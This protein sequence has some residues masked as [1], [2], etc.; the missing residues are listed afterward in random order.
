[1]KFIVTE[2]QF[3][4]LIKTIKEEEKYSEE[5]LTYTNPENGKECFIRIAKKK[6]SENDRNQYSAVLVCDEFDSGNL[7]VVAELP[8]NEP[9]S[10]KAKQ[11]IC[12]NIE[13]IYEI[14]DD[15]FMEYTG[16]GQLAEDI[17]S[18]RWEVMDTPI[19]CNID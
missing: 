2:N 6:F 8:V 14:L 4:K 16:E 9:T 15:M 3:K 7:N 12:D 5:E 13:R 1:M 17:E 10:K 18:S 19:F 11:K